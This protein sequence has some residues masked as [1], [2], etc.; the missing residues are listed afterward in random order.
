LVANTTIATADITVS[1]IDQ[2]YALLKVADNSIPPAVAQVA[3]PAQFAAFAQQLAQVALSNIGS[4]SPLATGTY[5]LTL[6]L[7]G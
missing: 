2:S 3:A 7:L 5:R 4:V 1:A 6:E